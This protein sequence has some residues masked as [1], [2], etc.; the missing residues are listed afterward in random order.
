[1]IGIWQRLKR[2]EKHPR[3]W[4][5]DDQNKDG[6]YYMTKDRPPLDSGSTP[7]CRSYW[8]ENRVSWQCRLRCHFDLIL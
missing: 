4:Q 3:Q 6:K 1:L 7:D 8:R 5:E 2:Q